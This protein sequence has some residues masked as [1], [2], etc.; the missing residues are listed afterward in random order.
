MA[1]HPPIYLDSGNNLQILQS[2][3]TGRQSAAHRRVR[4][5]DFK[6]LPPATRRTG[7]SE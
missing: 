4:T 5:P 6:V 2:I 1:F 7:A 3:V